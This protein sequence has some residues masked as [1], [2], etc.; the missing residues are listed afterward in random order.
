MEYFFY[1]KEIGELS[2]NKNIYVQFKEDNPSH[3]KAIDF[4]KNK[5]QET[6]STYADII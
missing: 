3:M 5:W 2:E 6:K 1:G 4:L